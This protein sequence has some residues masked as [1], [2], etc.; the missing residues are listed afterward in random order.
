MP[1]WRAATIDPWFLF[2]VALLGIAL[3]RLYLATWSIWPCV[4]LHWAV[5]V[6]WKALLGGPS[7]WTAG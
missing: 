7:P 3:S 1:G 5:V 4:V 2:C 6:G